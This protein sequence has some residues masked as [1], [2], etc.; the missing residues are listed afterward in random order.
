M[1]EQRA[2]C[3]QARRFSPDG[4]A[5]REFAT[6]ETPANQLQPHPI[7][8]PRRGCGQHRQ[9]QRRQSIGPVLGQRLVPGRI[10][11]A[12]RITNVLR[13]VP[14]EGG[15][16]VLARPRLEQGLMQR[17]GCGQCHGLLPAATRRWRLYPRHIGQTIEKVLVALAKQQAERGG[18]DLFVL[19]RHVAHQRA[20]QI[21][22]DAIFGRCGVA[23]KLARRLCGKGQVILTRAIGGGALRKTVIGSQLRGSVGRCRAHRLAGLRFRQA[24]HRAQRRILEIPRGAR[25]P[26]QPRRRQCAQESEQRQE[27]EQ[28]VRFEAVGDADCQGLSFSRL[29]AWRRER[30]GSPVIGKTQQRLQSRQAPDAV[31]RL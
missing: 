29:R 9:T 31:P 21:G 27:G 17:L 22:A 12:Q 8:A 23:Q 20:P 14:A 5:E 13:R 18:L 19:F 16:R 3:S 2:D 24:E 25:P 28:I 26:A 10:V 11:G 1:S 7:A 4:P 30:F 6:L 15:G